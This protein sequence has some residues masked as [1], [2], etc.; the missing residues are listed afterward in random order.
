MFTIEF[1]RVRNSDG[2]HAILD[3]I[4]DGTTDLEQAK[5]RA[6]SLFETLDMP[7]RP[8]ALRIIDQDGAEVFIWHPE[9]YST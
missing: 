6:Q 9:H 4:Q 8:D 2:A 1:F 5:V 7:Q 3:R